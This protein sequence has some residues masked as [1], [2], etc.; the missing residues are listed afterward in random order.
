MG[1]T[2]AGF[3]SVTFIVDGYF[4]GIPFESLEGLEKVPA[5]SYDSSIFFLSRKMQS[6]GYKAE[7]NN[8]AGFGMDKGKYIS[9]D[10][11]S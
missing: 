11:K 7:M 10:F 8:S 4:E 2:P 3:E 5:I 6:I 1:T 9:Y